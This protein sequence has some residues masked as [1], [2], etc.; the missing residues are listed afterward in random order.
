LIETNPAKHFTISFIDILTAVY[1]GFCILEL[2]TSNYKFICLILLIFWGVVAFFTDKSALVNA[3]CNNIVLLLVLFALIYF[4]YVTL[5]RDII[6]GMKYAFTII[7]SESPF[8][9]FLY[10][11]GKKKTSDLSKIL[12]WI[13]FVVIVYLCINILK[14]IAVDPNAA[15]KM[16]GYI[17]VY[18][19]FITGG[20]YQIAYALSLLVPFLIFTFR[21]YKYKLLTFFFIIV[22]TY[23]LIK[24]SYAIAILLAIFELFLLI[25]WSKK[26][27]SRSKATAVISFLC[28]AVALFLL[29][30]FIGDVFINHISHLFNGTFVERRMIEFG[31]FIKGESKDL[32]GV[33]ARIKLYGMSIKSFLDSPLIGTS[34]YTR[35]I[36]DLEAG[37]YST[38]YIGLHYV[39]LHSTIFDGFARIGVSFVLYIV[40]YWKAINRIKYCVGENTIMIVGVMFFLAKLINLADAFALGYIVYFVIPFLCESS[41]REIY[42]L[43]ESCT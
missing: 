32:N 16:A 21:E 9:L 2:N 30:G 29:R 26:S 39:G 13:G 15:R 17:N 3:I 35:F 19:D 5:T 18:Q 1:C 11:K 41:R 43:E 27:S 38:H 7:I 12:P 20:G 6:Y 25:I 31:Q 36:S 23:T 42:D 33:I 40:Y 8:I 10:Y 34:Y 24:C 37:N 4:L 22:F 28:L 14:L